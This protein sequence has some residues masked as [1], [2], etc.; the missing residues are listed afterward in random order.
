MQN[1]RG[2][3]TVQ[4]QWY[5]C[6]EKLRNFLKPVLWIRDILVRIRIH[7]QTT[8]LRIRILLFSS[9]VF[10][11][12]KYFFLAL[13]LKVTYI[14]ISPPRSYR[15]SYRSLK[16]VEINVFLLFLFYDGRI[17]IR[18]YNNGSGSGK[19]KNTNKMRSHFPGPYQLRQGRIMQRQKHDRKEEWGGGG[20]KS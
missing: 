11:T 10:K 1:S 7:V 12:P 6:G 16:T 9:V 15:R 4:C 8:D 5:G 3:K 14:Y 19:T 18:T 2:Q 13:F 17:R 20:V